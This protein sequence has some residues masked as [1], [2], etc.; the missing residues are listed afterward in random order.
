MRNL[1]SVDFIYLRAGGTTTKLKKNNL[2]N[3]PACHR[4][5]RVRTIQVPVN[6]LVASG[7][8]TVAAVSAAAMRWT[9]IHL[10]FVVPI[11]MHFCRSQ[12]S[13]GKIGVWY[14]PPP[15]GEVGPIPVASAPAASAAP[16]ERLS[17][18]LASVMARDDE[19]ELIKTMEG[20]IEKRGLITNRGR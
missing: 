13:A 7:D 1:E 14:G 17:T 3:P 18:S 16:R 5:K 9:H 12:P 8:V 4:R 15:A 20:A 11:C 19:P 2:T 10:T 6:K